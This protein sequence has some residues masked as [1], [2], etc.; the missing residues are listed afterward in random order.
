MLAAG[1][2]G[3]PRSDLAQLGTTVAASSS[4]SQMLAFSRCMRSHGEPTFPDPDA[5]GRIKQQLRASRI[6]ENSSQYQAAAR[7]CQ[8]LLPSGGT[9]Y[10]SEAEVQQEWNEF[11]R[12][13]QCMRHHGMPNWPDPTSRSESDKRPI[14]KIQP[15][16]PNSPI[17]P[18][19]PQ[20]KTKLHACDS[21]LR[22]QNPNHL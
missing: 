22:T 6:D 1:C 4:Q 12:F 21:L 7:A 3:S 14:F 18:D 16:D 20:I 11:R 13:T 19:S 5:Q 9:D 8:R 10:S 17:N 15:V 2:G